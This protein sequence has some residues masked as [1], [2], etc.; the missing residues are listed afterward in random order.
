VAGDDTKCFLAEE[1]VLFQNG[2]RVRY[3]TCTDDYRSEFVYRPQN[4]QVAASGDGD[5]MCWNWVKVSKTTSKILLRDCNNKNKKQKFSYDPNVNSLFIIF[6]RKRQY[7]NGNPNN[8]EVLLKPAK[9]VPQVFK[10]RVHGDSEDLEY[11]IKYTVGK[12]NNKCIR[13]HKNALKFGTCGA[14]PYVN[15]HGFEIIENKV[16]ETVQSIVLKNRQSG[17]CLN[18]AQKK[19]KKFMNLKPCNVESD[20]QKF[21]DFRG[22]EDGFKLCHPS[23]GICV[24]YENKKGKMKWGIFVGPQSLVDGTE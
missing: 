4:K 16:G 3:S 20:L 13:R 11:Q 2:Q 18:R 21:S 15:P 17:L 9:V 24:G 22:S 14:N 12:V 1:F 8:A 23:N 19:K 7:I 10:A 5:T 6:Q